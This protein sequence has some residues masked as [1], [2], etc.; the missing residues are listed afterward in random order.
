MEYAAGNFPIFATGWK[1]SPVSARIL[2]RIP[3]TPVPFIPFDRF[4]PFQPFNL[5]NFKPYPFRLT[6]R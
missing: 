6:L 5:F 4:Q 2:P 3:R 1:S